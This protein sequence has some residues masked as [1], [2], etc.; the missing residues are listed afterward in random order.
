MTKK[1]KKKVNKKLIPIMKRL[2]KLENFFDADDTTDFS[3][4]EIKSIK[5]DLNELIDIYAWT[6]KKGIL[7]DV[8]NLV[9][10]E[11]KKVLN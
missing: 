9:D 8:G 11:L 4:K 7:Y 10:D 2:V 3:K 5:K 1:Q 6:K